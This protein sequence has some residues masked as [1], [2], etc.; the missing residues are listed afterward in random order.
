MGTS[1]S[2]KRQWPSILARLHKGRS[3]A[4]RR[5]SRTADKP[6]PVPWV[7][8]VWGASGVFSPSDALYALRFPLWL[9]TFVGLF[10]SWLAYTR[11]AA[12]KW[13]RVLRVSV[14]TAGVALAAFLL[15]TGD[16]FDRGSEVAADTGQVAG[17]TES[18]ARGRLG[19]GQYP[20]R[21]GLAPGGRTHRTALEQ[22]QRDGARGVLSE[23]VV[24]VRGFAKGWCVKFEGIAA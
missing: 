5:L 13:R 2:P 8:W 1:I 21:A 20:R 4:L 9:L 11:F 24:P 22:P 6:S 12:P 15:T 17:D 19:A 10:Q 23:G 18:D 16:L 7:F 3:R 14:V